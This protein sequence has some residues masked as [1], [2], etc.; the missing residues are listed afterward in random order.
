M[1]SSPPHEGLILQLTQS[2]NCTR[3]RAID[4][5]EKSGNDVE[6]ARKHHEFYMQYLS[7]T[8]RPQKIV[9]FQ[10]SP[11][12]SSRVSSP[13]CSTCGDFASAIERCGSGSSVSTTAAVDTPSHDSVLEGTMPP[14]DPLY[15]E[16]VTGS[17]LYQDPAKA[18][19]VQPN[20]L[21]GIGTRGFSLPRIT[22][23]GTI[24]FGM[25]VDGLFNIANVIAELQRGAS[26]QAVRSY[27]NSFDQDTVRKHINEAV[28]GFPSMFYVVA[29]N[30]ENIVRLF[31]SHGGNVSAVHD[32]SRVPLLAFAIIHGEST[33]VNTTRV[34]ST[35][36]CHGAS[37]LVIP[38]EFYTPYA[39]DIPA[40]AA[41][42]KPKLDRD[43]DDSPTAWC[44]GDV[45]EKLAKAANITQRYFLERAVK[46]KRPSNKQRQVARRRN[47]EE[48]LGIPYFLIGQST[49][50][51][52]LIQR[53][54]SHLTIPTQKPLVL[55]FAGPSGHGK[56][57]LARQMGH[58]LSLQLHVVDCTV[59]NREIELFGPREPYV[60][61]EAGSPLNNFLA[62][63]AGR[64]CIVFLDEFE[65]TTADIRQSL[66]I[67]F[68][69]GEYEDRRNR[70]RI[71][72]SRTIWVL[73]TNGL[74]ATIQTFCQLNPAILGENDAER[75]RLAKELSRELQ[76]TSLDHFG[77]PVTGRISDFIPFLPFSPGEQ[78]VVTHKFLMEIGEYVRHPINLSPEPKE[79]LVGNIHLQLRRDAAVC[80]TLAKRHYRPELGARS[81]KTAAK[82]VEGILLDAYLDDDD[83]IRERDDFLDFAVDVLGDEVVGKF[84]YDRETAVAQEAV[85]V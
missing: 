3:E 11:S 42:T 54:I 56:T 83:E 31:L 38:A 45:R 49:A 18:S 33:S 12:E 50:A 26:L 46:M 84:M 48:L 22:S 81:L 41:K 47:A 19:D 1:T 34:V 27:L 16:G 52:W 20:L 82:V 53:L 28:E 74:D 80:T 43:E 58:L 79:Q 64:R 14:S 44:T 76:K 40:D 32:E 30:D 51:E 4:L 24:P 2:C 73:A 68:D 9:P 59:V 36:L 10:E 67:P 37:P 15:P 70:A 77:A 17:L 13:T 71:D 21:D 7:S 66:L 60:G 39:E 72:C 85:M 6:K 75:F 5:L 8:P 62:Q 35:L 61:A 23:S 78:A 57:E 29:M 55:C 63:H 69:N 25:G 65:K